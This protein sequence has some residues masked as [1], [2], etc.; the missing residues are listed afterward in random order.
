MLHRKIDGVADLSVGTMKRCYTY[1]PA[2]IKARCA[3][4]PPIKAVCKDIPAKSSV[5]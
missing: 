5:I 4:F 2:K 1:F 3:V